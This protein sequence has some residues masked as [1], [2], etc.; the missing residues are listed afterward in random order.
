MPIALG[1]GCG[2]RQR[3]DVNASAPF[4]RGLLRVVVVATGLLFSQLQGGEP[5]FAEQFDAT[6]ETPW[7]TLPAGWW[8]EGEAA[9]ARA[10]IEAGRLL[11]DA[12]APEVPGATVWLDRELPAD[13][14]VSFDVHVVEAI[15]TANNMNLFLEF[16]DPKGASLRETRAERADG[17]YPRYHSDRLQGTILTFLANGTP[18]QARLR[19]RQVPP[20]DPVV[21]EYHG[22][23]ARTGRTYQVSITRR[24][25]RFTCRIDGQ[26]LLDTTLPARAPGGRGGYLGFRTWRT[27]LWWDNLVVRR[28]AAP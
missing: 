1:A 17:R 26:T 15:G 9:G 4:F 12:T 2:V 25:A 8:L 3:A 27:K 28:P 5:I 19:V 14:E 10:R 18:E 13:V 23:H 20:F 21:Q 24:G 22:Y 6:P 7:G 11:V 16:R